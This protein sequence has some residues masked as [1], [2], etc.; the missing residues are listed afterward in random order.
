MILMSRIP[1]E[2]PKSQQLVWGKSKADWGKNGVK[3]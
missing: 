3:I 2:G 1:Q